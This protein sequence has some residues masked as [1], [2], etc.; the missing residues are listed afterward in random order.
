M[1]ST[2]QTNETPKLWEGY[3]HRSHTIWVNHTRKQ[4]REA[5][6][7]KLG[8]ILKEWESADDIELYDPHAFSTAYGQEGNQWIY[9]YVDMSPAWTY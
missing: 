1:S 2:R 4:V 9:T 8:T 5:S 3:L 6:N 7:G